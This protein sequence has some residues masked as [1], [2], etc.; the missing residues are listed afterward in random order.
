MSMVIATA[1]AGRVR[2]Q[3]L[4]SSRTRKSLF[5]RPGRVSQW[6]RRRSKGAAGLC[7]QRRKSSAYCWHFDLVWPVTQ[8]CCAKLDVT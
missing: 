8:P 5:G 6:T 7:L 1:A 2:S 4:D 3:A